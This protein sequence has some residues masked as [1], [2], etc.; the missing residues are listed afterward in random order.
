GARL[1]SEVHFGFIGI[2][3]LS[4]Q[5][6]V[7]VRARY[8]WT[9]EKDTGSDVRLRADDLSVGTTVQNSPWNIFIANVAALYYF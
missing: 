2:P 9:Q 6:S 8:Q 5:A 1:G 7:G 4:L 3:Q